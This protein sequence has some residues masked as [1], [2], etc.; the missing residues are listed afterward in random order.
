MVAAAAVIILLLDRYAAQLA[1]HD[2]KWLEPYR[3]CVEVAK[4]LRD[5]QEMV[6]MCSCIKV[7]VFRKKVVAAARQR[8]VRIR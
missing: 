1:E 3:S 4:K 6:A 5:C 2:V 7:S 8:G